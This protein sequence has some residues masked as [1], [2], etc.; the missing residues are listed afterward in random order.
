MGVQG[1]EIANRKENQAHCHMGEVL[2][3]AK[4]H[5]GDLHWSSNQLLQQA[6]AGV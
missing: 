2:W 3:Q 6:H 1:N 4:H 5:V